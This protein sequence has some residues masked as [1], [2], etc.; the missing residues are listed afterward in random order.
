MLARN[1]LTPVELGLSDAKHAA[2]VKVLGMM[3][4]GELILVPYAKVVE[5]TNDSLCFAPLGEKF[6]GHFHMAVWNVKHTCG[7]VACIGGTAELVG[8]VKFEN[9]C[10]MEVESIELNRLFYPSRSDKRTIEEAAH[11]LRTYLMTGRAEWSND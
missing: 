6:T 8:G 1:F 3:E 4:R 9:E 10:E 2:L 5:G 11:A 7:T